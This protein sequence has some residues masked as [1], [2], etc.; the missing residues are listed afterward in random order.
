MGTACTLHF[1][2]HRERAD[3]GRVETESPLSVKGACQSLGSSVQF[4]EGQSLPPRAEHW[5]A[6]LTPFPQVSF[7]VAPVS[8][9]QQITKLFWL[10][11]VRISS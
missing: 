10:A 7:V 8:G 4:P 3:E 2:K 11:N 6:Q 9:K 1:G 5:P